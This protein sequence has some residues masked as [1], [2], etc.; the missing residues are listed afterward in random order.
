MRDRNAPLSAAD[1]GAL[2]WH[3]M[4]GLL[5]AVVQDSVSGRVLM[6]GYM[7]RDAL[8]TTLDGGLVTFFS[9]SKQRLWAK[10]ESSGNRLHLHAVF[11]DC[12]DD[13]LLVIADADGPTCHTGTISCFGN[14][15]LEGAGWLAHLSA[16]VRE[17]A[18]SNDAGS[19][20]R[21]LLADGPARIAQKVGEEGVEVALAAVTRE[22]DGCAEEVADLLYHLAVLMEAKGFG[23]PDVIDRLKAR[24]SAA[25]SSSTAAS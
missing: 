24:H 12:D 10:G 15:A 25:A 18:A 23:W 22:A 16:I 19:Y 2:D 9:R 5:P 14:E 1:V 20:T 8:R 3:K 4:D 7:N 11:A 6:L 17:R 21:M 13:A